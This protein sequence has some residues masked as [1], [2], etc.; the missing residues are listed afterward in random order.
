MVNGYFFIF[1]DHFIEKAF[2][3]F[4]KIL[5]LKKYIK[6]YCTTITNYLSYMK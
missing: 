6:N 1:I 5:K 2:G 4:I 3:Y